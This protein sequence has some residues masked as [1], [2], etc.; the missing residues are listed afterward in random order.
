MLDNGKTPYA[1]YA[2]Y[3]SGRPI[4]IL[5]YN[6]D[7]YTG[8][9]SRPNYTFS[10]SGLPAQAVRVT[11][12]QA[13]A[14][15]TARQDRGDDVRSGGIRFA[16]GTCDAGGAAQLLSFPVRAGQADFN[17]PASEAWLISL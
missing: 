3:R 14:G 17:V 16:D 4:R 12:L 7:Y 13:A 10:L 9:G 2:I 15:A 11:K 1:V 8:Q 5:L 6:S